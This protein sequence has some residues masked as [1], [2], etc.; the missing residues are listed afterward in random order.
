M[1]QK[2]IKYICFFAL[3][4]LLLSP[5]LKQHTHVLDKECN[6]PDLKGYFPGVYAPK[7]NK[8]HWF[9]G[10]FQKDR[11]EFSKRHLKIRPYAVRVNNQLHYELL[12]EIRRNIVEGKD[13]YLFS[14]EYI[15][16]MQGL[17]FIGEKKIKEQAEKLQVVND[18]LKKEYDIDLVIAIALDKAYFYKEKIPAQYDLENMDST[19]YE[20]YLEVLKKQDI[21]VLDFN[22]YFFNQKEKSEH[23]F[24]NKH[25]VH[26]SLYGGM[27]AADSILSYIGN[28]KGQEVN[29]I[30]KSEI[31]KTTQVRKEDDDIGQ[32]INLFSPLEPDTFSYFEH[33]LFPDSLRKPYRPNIAL[34]GDSF[35]WTIWGQNIP[36]NYWG[37]S[38]LFLFYYHEIWDTKWTELSGKK[39]KKEQKMPFALKQDAIVLLYTP[40][41]M[42]NLGSDF[43]DDMYELITQNSE[44]KKQDKDDDTTSTT[45]R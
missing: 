15:H 25:G 29:R 4:F 30:D 7:F 17:N 19:N 26:W 23:K 45:D 11:E 31:T 22:E 12:G 27:I 38:T 32:S 34:I 42:G 33:H 21:H 3:L 44:V 2:I 20:T 14:T 24:A 6:E 36:H 35:C 13:G 16:A 28:L 43:I 18:F 37:D 5:A 10:T 41:N 8:N 39:I 9:K 40:M 1:I